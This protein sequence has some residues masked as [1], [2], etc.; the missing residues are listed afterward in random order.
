M[1]LRDLVD[2]SVAHALGV[3]HLGRFGRLDDH[4]LEA[5][6]VAA[7]VAATTT[8]VPTLGEGELLVA[9]GA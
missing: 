7:Q 6:I 5:A 1:L 8:M 3:A 9:A 4:A 2:T